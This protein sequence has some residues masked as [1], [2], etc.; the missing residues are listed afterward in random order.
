VT[1]QCVRGDNLV[2]PHRVVHL[3]NFGVIVHIEREEE[4]RGVV[5]VVCAAPVDHPGVKEDGL[6]EECVRRMRARW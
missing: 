5:V 4:H 3:P 2:G 1:V 6:Q